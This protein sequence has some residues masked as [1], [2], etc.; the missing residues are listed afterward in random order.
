MNSRARY[1]VV[2]AYLKA[3][4]R[5]LNEGIDENYEIGVLTAIQNKHLQKTSEK[6][7][8]LSKIAP[9]M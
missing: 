4:Q 8:P 3:L 6:Y 5:N 2:V 7:Y 9:C 1:R